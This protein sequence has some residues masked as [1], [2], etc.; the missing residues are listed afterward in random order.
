RGHALVA[1]PVARE[2][3]CHFFDNLR[4]P[5]ANQRE[6]RCRMCPEY[7]TV[8]DGA[9]GNQG[10]RARS[11]RFLDELRDAANIVIDWAAGDDVTEFGIDVVGSDAEQREAVAI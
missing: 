10:A 4:P 1:S 11:R 2:S 7:E 5:A 6:Q 8:P 3:I 9:A